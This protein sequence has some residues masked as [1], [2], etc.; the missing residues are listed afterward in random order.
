MRCRGLQELAICAYLRGFLYYG[1]PCVAPYCV[2]GV[3]EWC[4]LRHI[5]FTILVAR[6]THPKDVQHLAGH[7]SIQLTL[8]RYSHWMP[9]MGRNTAD[10]MD[11]ALGVATPLTGECKAAQER[12]WSD[13]SLPWRWRIHDLVYRSSTTTCSR[14]STGLDEL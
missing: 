10:G 2:P 14:R 1:L 4:Q 3:S 13:P 9:Y 5:C 8:D 6:G 7:T 11:E 12:T